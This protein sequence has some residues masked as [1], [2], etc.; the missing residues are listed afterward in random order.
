MCNKILILGANG[1][2]GSSLL[3]YF[4][5][6]NSFEVLG[7]TRDVAIAGFLQA[8]HNAKIISGIDVKN[9]FQLQSLIKEKQP[10][11]VLNCVGI[12]KQLDAAKN[13]IASI[14]I[15]SLL[16]HR[17]AEICSYNN[18]KLI[19]FSTDCV[20]KGDRGNYAEDDEPDAIDLYGRSK[21]L[22]EVSYDG[23]LTL[24][25]SIIGHELNTHHSL[26]NWFLSQQDTVTGYTNAIFSGLPTCYVAEVLEHYIFPNDLSGLYH[27]SVDPIS[28]YELLGI[29]NKIYEKK[30]EIQPSG[31]LKIDRSLDSRA[32]RNFT[33]FNPLPWENLIEKMYDEYKRYF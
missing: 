11:I 24:R 16:P 9:I 29:V 27:L 5:S 13:N 2:L 14:E 21:H 31:E 15:N 28:K 6:R 10:G 7:T 23:H 20:Y 17:L 4:S 18:A 12:I 32:L 1:M 26:I 3:R 8:K 19:H 33:N 25:T 22:G 30:L